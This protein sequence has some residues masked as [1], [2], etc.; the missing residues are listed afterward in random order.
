MKNTLKD[1]QIFLF[2]AYS[3]S[4]SNE[5][6]IS[7]S[8]RV[9]LELIK[10]SSQKLFV[11]APKSFESLIPSNCIF[12]STQD[13]QFNNLLLNYFYRTL[14]TIKILKDLNINGAAIISTSDF[15]CD[16][17][18]AFIF[19][20]KYKWYAFTYHLYPSVFKVK[21][22][23]NLFGNLVQFISFCLFKKAGLI[24]TTNSIS[25]NFLTKFFKILSIKK[26]N[27][28]LNYELFFNSNSIRPIDLVYVGRIKES[29]GIFELP[30][31][32]FNLKKYFPNL[33]IE[34]I[35]NGGND[36]IEFLKNL[37]LKFKV[38]EIIRI[39]TNLNDSQ[40]RDRLS[41]SKF[42]I[43]L[44]RE[45]GF[46]LV[47]LEALASGC[48][49]VGYNLPVYEENFLEF[50]LYMVQDFNQKDLNLLLV[51]RVKEYQYK[52]TH[53]EDF[54]NFEWRS[55]YNSIFIN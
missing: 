54:V 6:F 46:G 42:L 49:V 23:R 13:K 36:E 44:S 25:L 39:N 28:G 12:I 21:S 45:E 35:G 30:E 11:F 7:G 34:V 3:K 20:N 9:G 27:L 29:K 14:N 38:S 41:A 52:I 33:K 47:I 51:E 31:I 40:L 5:I 50:N 4:D 32:A 10:Q 1:S 18:P 55:I 26:I 17:I 22:L 37:I 16:T 48:Q 19:S 8:D 24:L 2:N 43:Q 53:K 15:F